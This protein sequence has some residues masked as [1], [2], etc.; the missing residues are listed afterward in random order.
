[1]L[2]V[3]R[4]DDSLTLALREH[5]CSRLICDGIRVIIKAYCVECFALC[6]CVLCIIPIVAH[7][8]GLSILH[9]PFDLFYNLN[10]TIV[11]AFKYKHWSDKMKNTIY[12]L[13]EGRVQ[14]YNRKIA[15]RGNIDIHDTN[16]WPLTFLA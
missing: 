5:L 15:E 11:T 16:T 10:V 4:K 13:V 2:W 14:K 1:M 3:W 6:I 8:S 9:C 12:H 7:V